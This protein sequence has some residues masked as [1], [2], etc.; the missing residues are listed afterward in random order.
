MALRKPSGVTA[1]RAASSPP[2]AAERLAP[3]GPLRSDPDEPSRA[4]E[5]AARFVRSPRLQELLLGGRDHVT[6]VRTESHRSLAPSGAQ[7]VHAA[8]L[9]AASL[10]SGDDV[11]LGEKPVLVPTGLP[12]GGIQRHLHQ[13]PE[14]AIR[15]AANW[16]FLYPGRYCT[17]QDFF[18]FQVHRRS[19][20]VRAALDE[21][22]AAAGAVPGDVVV[23]PP[24]ALQRID[25]QRLSPIARFL[26]A[27][28]RPFESSQTLDGTFQ[29]ALAHGIARVGFG[30]TVVAAATLERLAAGGGAFFEACREAIPDRR[31]LQQVMHRAVLPIEPIAP[32]APLTREEADAIRAFDIRILDEMVK[33][34]PIPA[35]LPLIEDAKAL[36]PETQF[37]DCHVVAVQHVL[38]TNLTLFKAF[39]ELGLEP[40]RAEI[41]GVPY[42]TNYV[43]EHA[44]R[45]RG[46]QIHTP[47]VVDPNDIAPAY[48]H[49]VKAALARAVERAQQDGRPILI[50]DDG[51]KASAVAAREYP[52][53]AHLFR[54]VEQTMRGVTEIGLV[55]KAEGRSLGFPV[56]DV[57]RSPL[58][59]HEIPKIGAQVVQEIEK[60]LLGVGLEAVA[61]REA[62]VMGFGSI[63]LGVAGALRNAGARVTVWDI[64]EDVRREAARAGF[65]V[66]AHRED[67][68]RG[69]SIIV[70][71]TGKR[72]ITREDLVLLEHQCVLA[73]ASSRDVE[74]DLTT[75]RDVA[76][77][78]VPLL[79]A[80]RGDR[81]FIT[82]V[83]RFADKDLVVLRNGFPLNFRGDYETGSNEDIQQTRAL[84]LLAASQAMQEGSAASLVP[85]SLETQRKFAVRAAIDP[86]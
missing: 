39:E 80:G 83:W 57:A 27:L 16:P 72:S 14:W 30:G 22:A 77:E 2:A 9:S 31:G 66:P 10:H 26:I 36:V 20:T 64:D 40:S 55:E 11:A 44:F 45:A 23:L 37:A 63:G 18:D 62:T 56:V 58:K 47:D 59:R 33:N 52:H 24:R 50:I 79:S 73:S 19:P 28:M 61:G 5:A 67:A 82:R 1:P 12:D 38:A 42:S 60:L 34:A 13:R 68:L 25:E 3:P 6:H 69:K 35:S 46:Y 51:G 41:I 78:T 49:A 48:E 43:V 74:I 32:D 29:R 76:T 65:D 70:G 75:N 54:G 85:L 4:E 86:P 17:A 84:M 15:E 8:R 7:T 71:T 21:I 81:R 53:A